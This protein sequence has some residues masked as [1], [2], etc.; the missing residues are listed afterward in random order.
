M[1]QYKTYKDSGVESLGEIPEHWEVKRLKL[2]GDII[3]SNVDKKTKEGEQ[4]VLLC[5]YVDVYKNDFITDDIKFMKAS[6]SDG[7]IE[8]LTLR[9]YDVIATKDSE[10]PLDIGVPALVED[11]FDGI[12][13]GYHLTL[14]RTNDDVLNGNYFYWVI[15][16]EGISQYFYTKARGVTRYAIGS[17]VFKNL[18]IPIPESLEEQS[19]IA[20]YLNHK[21]TQLDT[22]IAKKE[23]LISL[24][25]EERTA[26]INQ[27]VTKGLDPNVSMKESGIEWLG[28]I[29][30]H[31]EVV[32][33]KYILKVQSGKGIKN[34]ELVEKGKYIVYGGNG[35]MGRT[36]KISSD[37]SDLIIGRVGALCGNIHLVH[38]EKWISDNALFARTKENYEFIKFYLIFL[39]LNRLANKNAQPLIT[40]TMVKEQ[41]IGL[42]FID[43]QIEIVNFIGNQ[44]QRINSIISKT[45]QEI[46][47]LK[48]YKTALISEVVTGKVDV[49]EE[50]LN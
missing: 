12:V 19:Q 47:L 16:S 15:R 49:R 40:G 32:R 18:N 29:P 24:L 7:Q 39:D 4:K 6:A 11:D 31:W 2:L 1:K 26:M 43:E 42:P 3:P 25:Q 38:G 13:C 33:L 45:Q 46:N 35:E 44:S 41:S 50:T 14:I 34:D 27:A 5:N 17:N 22:L 20:K 37:Q 28:E 21:I 48:E 23:Q 10:D 36:D 9:K 30:E 8:K